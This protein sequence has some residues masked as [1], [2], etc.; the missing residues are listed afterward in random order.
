MLNITFR[1]TLPRKEFGEKSTVPSMAVCSICAAWLLARLAPRRGYTQMLGKQFLLKILALSNG[2][3]TA[4]TR[5]SG[6][7]LIFIH[8]ED[9]TL[10]VKK[11]NY[12][13]N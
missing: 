6:E 1:V 7:S 3:L 13:N 8:L 5:T 2:K 11:K 12:V 4:Q 10:W 9:Q